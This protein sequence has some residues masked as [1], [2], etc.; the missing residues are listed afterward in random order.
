MSSAG[1]GN[2]VH[3][4]HEKPPKHQ[5]LAVLK[6]SYQDIQDLYGP[7][8]HNPKIIAIDEKNDYHLDGGD[9]DE[10]SVISPT[11]CEYKLCK[12]SFTEFSRIAVRTVHDKKGRE[13]AR[14]LVTSTFNKKIGWSNFNQAHHQVRNEDSE[15][16]LAIYT[17]RLVYFGHPVSE[18]TIFVK[19]L[20]H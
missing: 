6:Q 13:Q 19:S 5:L 17:W 20:K 3:A 18:K 9:D 11:Y 10:K 4:A 7:N 1:E 14:L 16:F 12:G 8:P 15:N 2:A